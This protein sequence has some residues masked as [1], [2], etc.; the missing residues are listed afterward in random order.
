MVFFASIAVL[1]LAISIVFALKGLWV[2][3]PFAGLELLLLGGCFYLVA[4]AGNC[5]Q[6][7]SVSFEAVTIEKGRRR[8]TDGN[9]GGPEESVEFP[10]GWTRVKLAKNPGNWYPKRLLIGA[11]GRHVEIGEFLPEEEREA[12]ASRL[13][14]VLAQAA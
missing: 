8:S 5:R 11:Y 2:I 14:Q 10:R 3:L 12:L 4:C 9:K 13:N 1:S 6:V 7:I